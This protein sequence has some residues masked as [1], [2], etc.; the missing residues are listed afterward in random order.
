[1][2]EHGSGGEPVDP[3]DECSV[4]NSGSYTCQVT[5][6]TLIFV[7][8]VFLTLFIEGAR[9]LIDKWLSLRSRS[10]YRKVVDHIYRELSTL[11]LLSFSLFL[12]EFLGGFPK[13]VALFKQKVSDHDI[14]ELFEKMHMLLFVIVIS[15]VVLVVLLLFLSRKIAS[16]WDE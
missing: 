11:G 14:K 3:N 10:H 1:M 15:Y 2:G 4:A 5:T 13:I 16:S 12:T 6:L 7:L 9:H 8:I